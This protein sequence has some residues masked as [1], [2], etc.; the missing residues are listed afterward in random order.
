MKKGV[1]YG[2][3]LRFIDFNVTGAKVFVAYEDRRGSLIGDAVSIENNNVV[4][5]DVAL[6]SSFSGP[7]WAP[8]YTTNWEETDLHIILE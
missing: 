2:L 5:Y 7:S 3:L 1:F 8:W 4:H 6:R